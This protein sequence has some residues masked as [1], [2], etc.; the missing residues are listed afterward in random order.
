MGERGVAAR[1]QVEDEERVIRSRIRV[2]DEVAGGAH[3]LEVGRGQVLEY[4]GLAGQELCHRHRRV[5]REPPHQPPDVGPTEKTGRVRRELQALP[6]PPLDEPV[7]ARAHRRATDG[8]RA[9]LVARH[10][11]QQ[12]RRQDAQVVHGV[13][14]HFR[15]GFAEVEHHGQRVA[16]RHA[17]H[18]RQGR[19]GW[20]VDGGVG[21]DV[22]RE[23]HVLG[24]HRAPVVPA[25]GGVQ[26][27]GERPGVVPLPLLGE[28]GDEAGVTDGVPGRPEV[29]E[30]DEHLVEHRRRA[31]VVRRRRQQDIGL[32]G[33]GD[34]QRAA[35]LA[36][37]ADAP[38]A[39]GW[40]SPGSWPTSARS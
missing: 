23:R 21:V 10:R 3:P 11:A 14:E 5:G 39:R 40:R 4:V 22:E 2:G 17:A 25:G 6:R 1:A 37:A 32:A 9:K 36:R 28:L 30:L 26:V 33:R 8:G 27:E 18:A 16:R 13:V 7:A 34:D 38:P 20:G 19:P 31:R 15:I 12:V 35:I 29:G 24:T